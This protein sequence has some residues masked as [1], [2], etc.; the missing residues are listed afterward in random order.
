M[1]CMQLPSSFLVSTRCRPGCPPEASVK[2][3][4]AAPVAE[5]QAAALWSAR[6]TQKGAKDAAWLS[7][8]MR[9]KSLTDGFAVAFGACRYG[10]G[11]LQ[12]LAALSLAESASPGGPGPGSAAPW[13]SRMS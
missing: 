11:I 12:D 1:C 9:R 10:A 6:K 7:H 2:P 8:G 5:G 3:Q 13:P 4:G